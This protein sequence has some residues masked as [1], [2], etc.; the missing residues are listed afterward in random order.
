M[1][2]IPIVFLSILTF[3]VAYFINQLVKQV[4]ISQNLEAKSSQAKNVSAKQE[5]YECTVFPEK[6]TN[7]KKQ[8]AYTSGCVKFPFAFCTS[9]PKESTTSLK[10]KFL[11]GEQHTIKK[12]N[13]NTNNVARRCVILNKLGHDV[14]LNIR[15]ANKN[16][17]EITSSN[18]L[19]VFPTNNQA[20]YENTGKEINDNNTEKIHSNNN[21]DVIKQK[22][23][24]NYNN[25]GYKPINTYNNKKS[26]N[27]EKIILHHKEN[28]IDQATNSFNNKKLTDKKDQL[29]NESNGY[30]KK[31]ELQDQNYIR[32]KG[33][34]VKKDK[35][36]KLQEYNVKKKEEMRKYKT[37]EGKT[38]CFCSGSNKSSQVVTEIPNSIAQKEDF[39][40]VLAHIY[41][42]NMNSN[43]QNSNS[44]IVSNQENDNDKKI[45]NVKKIKI[46]DISRVSCNST[47]ISNSKILELKK[48]FLHGQNFDV[49][50]LKTK[51]E[52]KKISICDEKKLDSYEDHVKRQ[53]D[54]LIMDT[55]K[56]IMPENRGDIEIRNNEFA[57]K[58]DGFM[59]NVQPQDLLKIIENSNDDIVNA[60][61]KHEID[62][63]LCLTSKSGKK[64][65]QT[66]Q[67][68]KN[69]ISS[70]NRF[71]IT[72]ANLAKK[73]K[74]EHAITEGVSSNISD[75]SKIL[76]FIDARINNQ[77]QNIIDDL[78]SESSMASNSFSY[79]KR[80]LHAD[81]KI[82]N[83]TETNK[84]VSMIEQK[85]KKN[86][87]ANGDTAYPNQFT[88]GIGD[89]K[90]VRN[91]SEINFDLADNINI[92]T[93]LCSDTLKNDDNLLDLN[94][95][96]K[97]NPF[98]KYKEPNNLQNISK[99]NEQ[100]QTEPSIIKRKS[101]LFDKILK[102]NFT[103]TLNKNREMDLFCSKDDANKHI[104]VDNK[105]KLR[106]KFD[107]N[108][109]F[110]TPNAIQDEVF[111][112][113][114]ESDIQFDENTTDT[115]FD[116]YKKLKDLEIVQD[117]DFKH[118][119][120]DFKK[121]F[122]R[123]IK[124]IT[125][126]YTVQGKPS[127]KPDNIAQLLVALDDDEDNEE[128]KNYKKY[129][130]PLEASNIT[131]AFVCECKGTKVFKDHKKTTTIHLHEFYKNMG[132][133]EKNFINIRISLDYYAEIEVVI[134]SKYKLDL[135]KKILKNIIA[136]NTCRYY[137][138]FYVH[139][140]HV[141]Y[142]IN[143]FCTFKYKFMEGYNR[144][145]IIYAHEYNNFE[146]YKDF[147]LNTWHSCS[148]FSLHTD[149]YIDLI[150]RNF[151]SLEQIAEYKKNNNYQY[152][153]LLNIT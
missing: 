58:S 141:I 22:E 27:S 91:S 47:S 67:K 33:L 80:D 94:S 133:S 34:E 147:K 60:T 128:I 140:K 26:D 138:Q 81:S 92:K 64:T 62:K 56:K 79:A 100:A 103:K 19:E 37:Y 114:S 109:C 12:D 51:K 142:N 104:G 52:N 130:E 65:A 61:L 53:I 107:K 111:Q 36:R 77:A 96:L 42:L 6:Q 150:V 131:N 28:Y 63:K 49:D 57:Y 85:H 76:L 38:N 127:K 11:H 73:E 123:S 119:K 110:L 124:K 15:Q 25:D 18:F 101:C 88:D 45:F 129:Y 14:S 29:M 120:K 102:T 31:T 98:Q 144:K 84:K 118:P 55:N 105:A 152:T 39:K 115:S 126:N 35:V 7:L 132:I 97:D 13:A 86:L 116:L 2:K 134:H 41:D 40:R 112:E 72:D 32:E 70:E 1:R 87:K 106:F 90:V 48:K 24:V 44:K 149:V 54:P 151:P 122:Q 16:D 121:N 46:K 117:D 10:T 125:K 146:C 4:G 9:N 23:W 139:I 68:Q 3:I 113:K 5:S 82:S 136:K 17:Q 8:K 83:D 89:E 145:L 108:D 143:N 71:H 93:N 59:P 66:S 153:Y 50:I 30:T 43:V 78:Q 74:S 21:D 99:S 95:K 69:L 20:S 148:Y 137:N 75:V 135:L